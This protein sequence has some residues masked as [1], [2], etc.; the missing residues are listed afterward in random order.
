MKDKKGF[1]LYADLLH[2]VE[3][4]SATEAGVLFLHLLQYVNDLHPDAPD[5]LTEIIFEPIKQTLKRDLTKWSGELERKSESGA[6]G[7]LKRWH[8]DLFVQ[9]TKNEITL[10]GALLIAKH[11]TA[12]KNIAPRQNLSDSDEKI[13][14]SVNVNDT[15]N[16]NDKIDIYPSF[17]DFWNLYDK[18]VG[19]I[20]K[21]KKKWDKL[22]Q[23][24]RE[25]IMLHLPAYKESQPDKQFR[26]DPATYLNNSSWNDEIIKKTDEHSNNNTANKIGRINQTE[27]LEF[28]KPRHNTQ[29]DEN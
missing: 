3:K 7:N 19:D 10:S 18:K 25:K 14:V 16:V 1:L 20:S 6:I 13:A 9:V 28:I 23:G 29:H 5:R 17:L 26:K 27:I 21:L 4:L 15:V 24:A 22:N 11:R 2:V 8:P 12:T